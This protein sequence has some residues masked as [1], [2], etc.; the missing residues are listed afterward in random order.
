MRLGTNIVPKYMEYDAMVASY[1]ALYQR[2]L[3]D[4]QI[5]NR[6]RNKVRYMR[7]SVRQ[8]QYGPVEG[9]AI[10]GRLMARGILAGGWF[11]LFH[12]LRSLPLAS[13]RLLPQTITDWI[14]GL[15]MRDYVTLRSCSSAPLQP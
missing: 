14:M 12:F 2:L 3:E 5:A 8:S 15:A 1:K 13:P 9:L 11:R 4:R 10:L 7:D 6:I